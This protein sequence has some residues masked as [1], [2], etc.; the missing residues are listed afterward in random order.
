MAPTCCQLSRPELKA[1][2][3]ILALL[4]FWTAPASASGLDRVMA[5]PLTLAAAAS[6]PLRTMSQK[7]SPG[8]WWVIMAILKRGVPAACGAGA[9]AAA[10]AWVGREGG[11]PALQALATA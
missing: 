2:T 9:P 5:M 4:A 7:V 6:A 1:T 3:G 11:P 8:A 10:G